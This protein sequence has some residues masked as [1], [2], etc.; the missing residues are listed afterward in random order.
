MIEWGAVR[1]KRLPEEEKKTKERKHNKNNMIFVHHI[2]SHG[3]T[4]FPFFSY[5]NLVSFGLNA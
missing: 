2:A 5:F 4:L 1:R 3:F